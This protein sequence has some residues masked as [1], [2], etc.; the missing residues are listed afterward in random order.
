MKDETLNLTVRLRWTE[1]TGAFNAKRKVLMMGAMQF[2]SYNSYS[3]TLGITYNCAALV[4]AQ[5]LPAQTEE[6]AIEI[7]E[8]MAQYAIDL[9]QVKP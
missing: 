3:T 5:S 2:A 7:C 6:Q 4:I 9:M 8:S 1:V